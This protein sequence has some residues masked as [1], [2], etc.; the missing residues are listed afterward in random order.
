MRSVQINL[1]WIYLIR[2]TWVMMEVIVRGRNPAT[3]LGDMLGEGPWG[4]SSG[5]GHQEVSGAGGDGG[6]G[7]GGGDGGGGGG[8]GE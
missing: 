5:D 4:G 1:L 8:G 3:Y 2:A 7:S 6:D